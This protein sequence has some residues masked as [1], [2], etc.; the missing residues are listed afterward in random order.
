MDLEPRRGLLE[1]KRVYSKNGLKA[2]VV[3]KDDWEV[4][5]YRSLFY[6]HPDVY[7]VDIEIRCDCSR[8]IYM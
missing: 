6:L 5:N 8:L 2:H 1:V 4:T 7:V 3:K